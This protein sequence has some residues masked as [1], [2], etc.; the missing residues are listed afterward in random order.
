M[1]LTDSASIGHEMEEQFTLRAKDFTDAERKSAFNANMVRRYVNLGLVLML[2]MARGAITDDAGGL[3]KS[4]VSRSSL[5]MGGKLT[6]GDVNGSWRT[7]R[8]A[9]SC[10]IIPSSFTGAVSTRQIE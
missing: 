8:R 3:A 10:F 2:Q 9:M 5:R 6:H 1:Y 7:L 4:L